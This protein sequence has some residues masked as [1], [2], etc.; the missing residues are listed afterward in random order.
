MKRLIGTCRSLVLALGL[1]LTPTVGWSQTAPLSDLDAL[2]YIAS[3]PDLI[4]VLGADAAKGRAHYQASGAR[5]GR[6][7]SF[8]PLYYTASYP[9]LIPAFGTNEIQATTHYIQSGYREGRRVNFDP[10]RYAASYPDLLAAFAGDG[11]KAAAHYIQMGFREG[12]RPT[13]SDTDALSYI[14]SYV[15]LIVAFGSD[16]AQ[17]IRHYVSVGYREGRRIVFDA[18]AYIANYADLRQAFGTDTA[19]ATRHWVERGFAEGRV[20]SVPSAPAVRNVTTSAN[21]GGSISPATV[22]VVPGGTASF[23]L[24]PQGNFMVAGVYGCG[25]TLNGNT[26]TTGRVSES[27][28]IQAKFVPMMCAA[29]LVR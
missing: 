16:V 29:R 21:E 24:S 28:T 12:R 15:D 27:C 3:Y 2:R 20:A 19:A 9:D 25:G 22:S 7:I 18:I 23:T 26:Y 6:Q 14:A 11:R 10:L 5:E 1:F 4:Q 17:G 8:E 13:F